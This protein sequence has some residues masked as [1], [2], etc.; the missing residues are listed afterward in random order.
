MEEIN[1][2]GGRSRGAEIQLFPLIMAL[3]VKVIRF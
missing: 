2:A 1:E 3:M